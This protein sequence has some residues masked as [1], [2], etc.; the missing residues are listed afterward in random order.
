MLQLLLIGYELTS[1]RHLPDWAILQPV[2]HENYN[3][4]RVKNNLQS[5]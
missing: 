2:L 1:S 3:R 4:I 5:V